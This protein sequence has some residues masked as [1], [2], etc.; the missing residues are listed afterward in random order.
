MFLNNA[1]GHAWFA[2]F[3]ASIC[4]R[5]W[6][7]LR[8]PRLLHTLVFQTHAQKSESHRIWFTTRQYSN[9]NNNINGSPLII[10]RFILI[11]E[12]NR[13]SAPRFLSIWKKK[14]RTWIM[15]IIVRCR[16]LNLI[17]NL[18]RCW[19]HRYKDLLPILTIHRE[20]LRSLAI[21][22]GLRLRYHG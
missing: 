11:M 13:Y 10:A 3:S 16:I 22:S 7:T 18:W 5:F 19:S 8:V 2:C 17:W 1:T 4:D 15:K 9:N 21:F 6:V 14:R 20:L 12:I